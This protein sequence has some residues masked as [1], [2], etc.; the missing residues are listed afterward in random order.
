MILVLPE[1]AP[2]TVAFSLLVSISG[3]I[4]YLIINPSP[5]RTTA[6]LAYGT[7]T[8]RINPSNAAFLV[9]ASISGNCLNNSVSVGLSITAANNNGAIIPAVLLQTPIILILC[10]ALSLGPIIVI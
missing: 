7:I 8:L 9:T 3:N 4:E 2:A 5:K 6:I 10:A 1:F